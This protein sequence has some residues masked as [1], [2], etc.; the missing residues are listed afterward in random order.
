MILDTN[1]L[2]AMASGDPAVGA[3]FGIQHSRHRRDYEAWLSTNLP[4]CQVLDITQQ[5]SRDSHF[6]KVNDL[7]RLD[8]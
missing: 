3:A 5:M 6:D 8:W 2:S 7:R 1:A 4:A